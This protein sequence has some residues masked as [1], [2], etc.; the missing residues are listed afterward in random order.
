M[1]QIEDMKSDRSAE[2]DGKTVAQPVKKVTINEKG[3]KVYEIN[4]AATEEDEGEESQGDG[5]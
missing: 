2:M 3:G 5:M 4:D 1:K